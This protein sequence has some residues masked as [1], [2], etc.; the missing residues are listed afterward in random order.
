MLGKRIQFLFTK[1]FG[2]LAKYFLTGIGTIWLIIEFVSF[3]KDDL[4]QKDY[5]L[6]LGAISVSLVWA[7]IK[8]FPTIKINKKSKLSHVE[9]EIRIKKI[10][11]L[12]ECDIS[13]PSSDCF[14]TRF[15]QVISPTTVKAALVNHEYGGDYQ[16]FDTALEK[17]ITNQNLEG[18]IDPNKK[19]G[20]NKRFPFGTTVCI[21]M[22]N[23]SAFVTS[24]SKMTNEG[25]V[26]GTKE[27]IWLGLCGLWNEFRK[28]GHLRPIA[29]PI[30]G[31][32][33][34]RTKSSKIG[35]VQLIILSFV[36]ATNEGKVSNKLVIS[37]LEK[38]YDPKMFM[39]LKRFL[40]TVEF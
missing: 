33:Y 32:G 31:G 22:N 28:K 14:D 2:E 9:I 40:E 34:T 19:I 39:E 7:I 17:S 26:Q 4:I 11:D 13:I 24:M 25:Y 12:K 1:N 20:K 10:I 8:S 27:S 23:R 38:D 5:K 35:L 16:K 3:F 15:P 36:I 6:F 37:I 21:R 30:W 18:Q 29:L